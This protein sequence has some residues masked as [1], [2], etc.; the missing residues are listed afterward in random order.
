MVREMVDL[1]FEAIELSHG[2]R[3]A[4]VPGVMKAVEERVVRIAST[5]NFCPLPAGVLQAAPNLYEPSAADHRERENWIRQTRHSIDF[6]ARMGADVLVCHL[7]SVP[8]RWFKPSRRL[9]PYLRAHPGAVASGD[10]AYRALVE[11]AL[12][13]MRHRMGPSWQHTQ[14]SLAA[15]KDHAAE[16]GVRLALENRESVEELPLDADYAG[17]LAGM[18]APQPVGYWHDTGHAQIKA[19]LGIIEHQR[20]LGDNA[21][22]LIG[23]HLHD[24]NAEGED[25]Q[26]VGS[27]HVD[28]QMVSQFWRPE[29][30]LTLE[31]SP[32][33]TVEDVVSSKRVVDGLLKGMDRAAGEAR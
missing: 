23:F 14:D 24:V 28:F 12:A 25:H 22:R 2:I 18:P 1:G 11:Q 6:A 26:A 21:S 32:H 13:K 5:H 30:K 10:P 27:G 4:L 3:L 9:E 33:A 8:F 19:D 31:L 20:L 29:H 15:V 16:R 7:G 17:F